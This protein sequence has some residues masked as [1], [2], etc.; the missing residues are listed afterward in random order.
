MI[1]SAIFTEGFRPNLFRNW[2]Y[3]GSQVEPTAAMILDHRGT[4]P[5]PVEHPE[6]WA[7]WVDPVTMQSLTKYHSVIETTS[8]YCSS[9][10]IGIWG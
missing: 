9:E 6:P 8:G 2:T 4:N 3:A 1:F 10:F 7:A 5:G